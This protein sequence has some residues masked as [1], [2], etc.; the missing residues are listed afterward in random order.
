MVQWIDPNGCE[1]MSAMLLACTASLPPAESLYAY[2]S[3][4]VKGKQL[5]YIRKEQFGRIAKAHS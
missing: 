5:L 3:G 2:L 4:Y 1:N